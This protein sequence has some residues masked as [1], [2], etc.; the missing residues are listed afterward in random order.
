MRSLIAR[1][2]PVASPPAHDPAPSIWS[3]RFQRLW[4]TPLFRSL[5]RIGLPAFLLI[6][7][8]G[9]YLSDPANW[10]GV[11]DQV[12]ELR[13]EIENR[14]EFRVNLMTI[15]GASP[16]LSEDLRAILALDLPVSSFDLDLEG[17]RNRLEGFPAV[18][19]ARIRIEPGGYLIATIEER[20]PVI[21]W[22]TRAEPVLLDAAGQFVARLSEREL[23]TPLPMIAGEGADRAVDEA[24][25]LMDAAASLGDGMHGLVRMGERR[26]D[27]V[28]RN[29]CRI[30][31]PARDPLTALDRVMALNDAQDV[32]ERDIQRIDMRNPQ[33]PNI[34]LSPHALT[35]LRRMRG[36]DIGD[37]NG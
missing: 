7:G 23:P 3:Y 36:I 11:T 28:L 18:A 37:G 19:R 29:G 9:W 31:L 27:V 13:R 30:L 34:Q 12:A 26:W 21:I 5:L 33:R 25:A 8:V 10:R 22:Q 2:G 24:L 17:L 20:V 16:Q 15:D 6:L 32:L 4:L 35:E 1:R 14:P